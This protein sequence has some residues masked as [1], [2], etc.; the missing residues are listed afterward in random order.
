[1]Q[2]CVHCHFA[3]EGTDE[4]K[5]IRVGAIM[6]GA[7]GDSLG[8]IY[9]LGKILSGEGMIGKASQTIMK[10]RGGRSKRAA[11]SPWYF[12]DQIATE[13]GVCFP[14]NSRAGHIRI[15]GQKPDA[16]ILTPVTGK[17]VTKALIS[18]KGIRI[19]LLAVE[20]YRFFHTCL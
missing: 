1:M 10:W 4:I 20:I 13:G 16:C 9:N 17:L 18:R 6:N 11:R 7:P 19:Y 15:A 2:N 5:T 3:G 14:V 8:M 12:I